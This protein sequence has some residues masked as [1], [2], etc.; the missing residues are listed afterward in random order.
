V[1]FFDLLHFSHF[2]VS[3]QATKSNFHLGLAVFNIHD[4]EVPEKLVHQVNVKSLAIVIDKSLNSLLY[5]QFNLK[6]V[7]FFK[8]FSV[9]FIF[10]LKSLKAV[11][12]LLSS[13]ISKFSSSSFH[14]SH[15][16]IIDVFSSS[17]QGILSIAQV[18]EVGEA[19]APVGDA[20]GISIHLGASISSTIICQVKVV[21]NGLLTDG[22]EI[23]Q[24]RIVVSFDIAFI[25]FSS[26]VKL[27]SVILVTS[28]SPLTTTTFVV[29]EVPVPESLTQKIV[30][31]TAATVS[32]E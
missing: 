14:S 16:I 26:L 17:V 19:P 4:N 9:T 6:Y 31:L 15:Q 2:L 23:L 22:V 18:D 27:V 20:D 32:F 5:C 3:L 11:Q 8:V 30:H 28:T 21:E 29:L 1:N 13:E 24:V 12:E 10:A 25:K 7:N